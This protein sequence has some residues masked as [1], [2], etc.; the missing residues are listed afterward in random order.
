MREPHSQIELSESALCNNLGFLREILK[1]SAA[2][3]TAVVK[4]NAYGHG[5]ETYIPLAQRCGLS[6]FATFSGD[7]AWRVFKITGGQVDLMIMGMMDDEE[8]EWAV[9]NEVSFFVFD[10]QRLD[11]A[12][13][14]AR[15]CGKKARL[16]I[17]LETGMNRSGIDEEDLF[18]AAKTLKEHPEHLRFEGLCTHFAGAENISNYYR[19]KQQRIAYRRLKRWFLQQGLVPEIEHI[20]CSAAVVRYPETHLDLVRVGILQYGFWPSQ[21]VLIEHLRA[22]EVKKN[23]LQPILTWKSRVMDVKRVAEG[24]Y[25]GY[26]T[27]FLANK[28]M[29][30]CTVPVGYCHGF[31]RS[32]SN[33][34]RVLIRGQRVAV[35]GMVNMN[36][37]TVDI[38]D[39][40]NVEKGDEVILIG[41]QGGN[42]ITVSS[43]GDYSSQVNYELLTRLPD[44]IP[45]RVKP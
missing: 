13:K 42:E 35:I 2:R 9:E 30:I 33:T 10:Q 21:E 31:S 36:V 38:T 18:T 40:D 12:L 25:V 24:D 44:N 26:G 17:E 41:R 1:E 34:G 27:S 37:I 23:P 45:R 43:F 15:L 20:A 5:I 19:V 6:H 22:K 8:V 7:E 14:T 39:L 32:L 11:L 4:G 29:K 28:P 16:H 3:L